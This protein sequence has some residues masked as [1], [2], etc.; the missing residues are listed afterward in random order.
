[1][2]RENRPRGFFV[3][4]GYTSDAKRERAAFHK[5]TGQI[6]KLLRR[7]D[8]ANAELQRRYICATGESPYRGTNPRRVQ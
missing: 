8:A 7:F 3:S 2:E 1:M 5:R 4:F 6:I